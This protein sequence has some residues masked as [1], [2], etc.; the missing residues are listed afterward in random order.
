MQLHRQI[1]EAMERVWLERVS[2][3]VAEIACH[4]SRSAVLPGAGRGVAFAI[5]AHD[6]VATFVRIALE[7]GPDTDGCVV[8]TGSH[9]LGYQA[10]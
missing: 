8:V 4:Y 2:D 6:E 10:S 9:N 3:H 7:L 1:A 5:A